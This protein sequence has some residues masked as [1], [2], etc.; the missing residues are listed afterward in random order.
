MAQLIAEEH[1]V[2]LTFLEG[3]G[4]FRITTRRPM[5]PIIRSDRAEAETC[6]A[7]EVAASRRDP[8]VA[9][10]LAAGL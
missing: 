10:I 6:F 8:V 2:R 3:P 1:G 7:R 5:Q 9:R 4:H